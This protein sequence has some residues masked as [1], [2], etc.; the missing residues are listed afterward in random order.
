M[1]LSPGDIGAVY[2]HVGY[3]DFRRG[4]VGLSSSVSREFLMD[5][6][7][8]LFVFCNRSRNR[9][10][11]LYWDDSGFALWHKALEKEKFKWP[12]RAE[13][14]AKLSVEELRW[15]LRGINIDAVKSHKKVSAK[16]FF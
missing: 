5:G 1:F 9:L 11:V 14:E 3:V 10:R 8:V 4:I 12:K 7:K 13:A 2:L 6:K 16:A 15:L